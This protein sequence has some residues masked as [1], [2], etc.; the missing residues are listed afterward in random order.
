MGGS[1]N[2]GYFTES[3]QDQHEQLTIAIVRK[4][5]E[6]SI[7]PSLQE[8]AISIG[9]QSSFCLHFSLADCRNPSSMY[10]KTRFFS[11]DNVETTMRRQEKAIRQSSAA[12]A[13]V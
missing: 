13:C 2:V 7:K 3:D 12:N 5:S 10:L 1:L 9:L 8:H 6:V 11:P 4:N